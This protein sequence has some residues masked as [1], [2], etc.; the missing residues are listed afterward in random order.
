MPLNSLTGQDVQANVAY[1]TFLGTSPDSAY[2]NR[3]TI[4][5][6]AYGDYHPANVDGVKPSPDG[7][8]TIGDSTFDVFVGHEGESREKTTY[9]FVPQTG[10][11]SYIGDLLDFYNYLESN[12]N[13]EMKQH[14]QHVQAGTSV[15]LGSDV[16]FTTTWYTLSMNGGDSLN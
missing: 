3:V 13:L 15:A 6:G 14:L 5:L 12:Y 9:N 8:A 16:T 2:T 10:I 1:N 11:A 7:S 4:W